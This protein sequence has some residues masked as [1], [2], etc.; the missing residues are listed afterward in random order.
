[1]TSIPVAI[2][3][4]W[5]KNLK[6]LYLKNKRLFLELLLHFSNLEQIQTILS[7]KDEFSRLSISEI[8]DTGKGGY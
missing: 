2:P 3:R 5:P 1:M 8:L 4:I 7:K 6:R